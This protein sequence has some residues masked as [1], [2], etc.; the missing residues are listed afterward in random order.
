MIYTANANFLHYDFF[1]L[2][3]ILTYLSSP[4]YIKECVSVALKK[5][6]KCFIIHKASDRGHVNLMSKVLMTVGWLLFPVKFLN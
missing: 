6:F 3:T 5:H 2:E 1:M 4:N